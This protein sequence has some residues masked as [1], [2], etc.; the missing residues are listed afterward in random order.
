MAIQDATRKDPDN[1]ERRA[2]DRREFLKLG[3]TGVALS[4]GVAAPAIIS[5]AALSAPPADSGGG[6]LPA[7]PTPADLASDKL[8]HHFRDLFNPPL[9][10][11]EWGCLQAAKS[12]SGI[13]SIAF[14]PFICCG[15]PEMPFSPGNLI[16]CEI[17]MNGQVLTSYPPPAGEVA[18][19]WYPHQIVRETVAQGIRFSTKTFTPSKQRTAAEL[20]TVKNESHERRNLT[21]GFD[22][23]AGVAVQ[24]EKPWLGAAPSEADNKLTA[25]E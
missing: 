6:L 8:V 15:T 3:A 5:G 11:N 13:T 17:F 25:S 24:R 20:I 4:P 10:N 1:T 7:I 22:M 21:L 2:L 19:T 9:A 23:R 14:P 12:V 16:T 18:Y